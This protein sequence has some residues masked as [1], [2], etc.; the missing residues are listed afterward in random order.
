MSVSMMPYSS[1]ILILHRAVILSI[2]MHQNDLESLLKQCL[3]L[4]LVSTSIGLGWGGTFLT[5]FQMVRTLL[6]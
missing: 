1:A 5:S 2:G 4:S 3:V 6:V